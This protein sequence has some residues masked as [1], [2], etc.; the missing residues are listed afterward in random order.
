[1]PYG[2]RQHVFFWQNGTGEYYRHC[3]ALKKEGRLGGWKSGGEAWGKLGVSVRQMRHLPATL[4]TGEF[5][6]HNAAAIVPKDPDHLPA[7][8][9]FC[10]SPEF[11]EA[12][13][14]I[15][16]KTNVTNATLVKIPFNL[17]HWQGVAKSNAPIPAPFSH[18]PTQWL[19]KGNVSDSSDPLQVAVARML[20]YRWPKQTDKSDPVDAIADRDG[21][22]CI[23]AIRGEGPAAERLLDILRA[24]FGGSWSNALQDSLLVGTGCKAGTS[25]DDW[26]REGSFRSTAR[27]RACPFVWHIWDGRKEVFRASSTTTS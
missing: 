1:M 4:Y 24:A 3:M 14:L 11:C 27:V 13:R 6:D 8:W 20:G 18:D 19:F 21:I 7:I 15:D 16:Q 10:S 5:F 2:G 12:V 9:A 26:L 23:P 25:L 22:V 17:E